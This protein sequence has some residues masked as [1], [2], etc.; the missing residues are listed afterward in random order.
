[1]KPDCRSEGRHKPFTFGAIWLAA[2]LQFC[3]TSHAAVS[4]VDD[5][6]NTIELVAPARRI[7]SLAPHTTELLF[8]A[9][10][11]KQLV[12]VS[13][14]SD[15][16]TEARQ[17]ASVGNSTQLDLERIVRLKPDLVVAWQSGNS[18][19]QLAR[20]KALGIAVFASEPRKLE[21]IASSI[22]RLAVLGGTQQQ[23]EQSAS[24]FRQQLHT[25][26]TR[27]AGRATVSVFYQIWPSPLMTLN[28]SHLVSQALSLC[29]A[30][31]IFAMLPQLVPTVSIEAVVKANPEVIFISDEKSTSRAM[32]QRF[33]TLTAVK[34]HNLLAINGTLM[35]RASPRILIGVADLCEQLEQA[36]QRRPIQP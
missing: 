36:R 14:Y 31:N 21:D 25:L 2:L 17:I 4:A 6:G 27:Y 24:A 29:G 16:P 23:G 26:R 28:Q 8:A 32:W 13:A 11:G 10:A 35:N 7:I 18:A 34:Q 20:L 22:E 30:G 19:R 9:G 15:F 3:S 1:M 12:G 5:A 33:P